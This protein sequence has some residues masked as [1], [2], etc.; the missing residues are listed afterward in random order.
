[1]RAIKTFFD[2]IRKSLVDFPF[3]REVAARPLSSAMRYVYWV[4]FLFTLVT[5]LLT[6]SQ[7]LASRQTFNAFIDKAVI[8]LPELYPQDL[9]ITIQDGKLSTNGQE[10]YVFVMPEK[11]ASEA[12]TEMPVNLLVIDTKARAE[13]FEDYQTFFLVTERAV[14]YPREVNARKDLTT[15]E[16]TYASEISFFTFDDIDEF[17]FNR[18]SYDA[19]AQTL[20]PFLK[21]A[22]PI[23]LWIIISFMTILPFLG[24]GFIMLGYMLY[25]L[26]MTLLVWVIS[27]I[28]STQWTYKQLYKM[29]MFGLTLPMFLDFLRNL[30]GV[31]ASIPFLFTLIFL[32]WMSLVLVQSKQERPMGPAIK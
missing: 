16:T 30:L 1:M 5:G 14:V 7:M 32:V 20:L 2:E 9:V 18:A 27:R 25:L 10:P 4:S 28:V 8:E 6:A 24:A 31:G 17:Q 12:E 3:Y 23:Y 26:V 11:I 13:D 22:K 21:V 29:S 15:G 19:I